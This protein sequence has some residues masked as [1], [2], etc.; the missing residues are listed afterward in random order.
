MNL[1]RGDS[2]GL[3]KSLLVGV[4]ST[5]S[6]AACGPSNSG[7]S[8][9]D[10]TSANQSDIIGGTEV[11]G[12]SS[13]SKSIVGIYSS[14][15]GEQGGAICTGSLLPNNL[16]VTAAHCVDDYMTIVFAPDMD[17]AQESQALPVDKVAVSPYWAS[18]Q[19]AD[20]DHGDVALLHYSGTTPA[21][22]APANLLTD[23]TA[24]K[25]GTSVLLA[26]YG[27]N[28]VKETPIDVKTYPDLIADIQSG[29]VVC[30]DPKALT[31]CASVDMTGAGL[32]RQTTVT[33]SNAKYAASVI[34]L[35]QTKG[36]GACHGDS[37]GPAYVTIGGKLYLW[38]VTSRGDQ[39]PRNNCS[40]YSVYTSLLFH[41]T[42]LNRAAK[43]LTTSLT[44]PNRLAAK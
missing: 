25:N 21:S 24:I 31:N 2:V 4:L 1:I 14:H 36:T 9:I 30:D 35:N 44:D 15:E 40:Q 8:Q 5:L 41:K 29:K 39:D 11:S 42:W 28:L 6:L 43:Q 37:G 22:Y 10:A 12:S 7:S 32:L 18:R 33:V 23:A 38:G 20:K 3:N 26:G 17:S 27:V 34:Q 16:V 19:N 13:L